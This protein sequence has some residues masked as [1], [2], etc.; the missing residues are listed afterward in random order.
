MCLLA[1]SLAQHPRYALLLAANRD[2]FFARAAA[3][4]AWWP[5]DQWLGG[6]D[7]QAGGSWLVLDRGGRLAMLTNVREPGRELAGL[8]SRGELP[9]LA[10]QG[11]DALALAAEPRNGFNLLQIDSLAASARW[12]SNRPQPRGADLGPGLYGLSNAALD[13]PWPKLQRLKQGVAA[14]L[15]SDAPEAALLAALADAEPADDD[16]LPDTGIGLA[17]ERQ[18]SSSFIRI[19]GIDGQAIYGTRCST[20]V[21]AERDGQGLQIRVIERRFGSDG[22][23]AGESR[24]SFSC[25]G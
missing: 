8:A 21:I 23:V 3:P 18:L 13:T 6:R 7:L 14:A 20:L 17:R 10:L 12:T 2:E 5:G 24:E 1:F 4:L 9:L 11:A 15:E 22:E 16:L 25:E 19:A